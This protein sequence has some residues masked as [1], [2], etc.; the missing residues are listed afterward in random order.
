[1]IKPLP[2]IQKL[3]S[4]IPSYASSPVIKPR[5]H[6]VQPQ[7]LTIDLGSS[8]V[9]FK[10]EKFKEPLEKKRND[11]LKEKSDDDFFLTSRLPT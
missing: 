2:K 5:A 8:A 9:A 7:M 6:V 3:E 4:F 10:K 11:Y 1:M